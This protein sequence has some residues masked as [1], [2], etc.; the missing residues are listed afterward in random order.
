MRTSRRPI[1]RCCG[2][3]CAKRSASSSSRIRCS[4]SRS[5]SPGFTVGEAEGLR[6]AMSRKRSHAALESYRERFV[7]RRDAQRRR[8]RH[9][10][11]MVYDKLVAFSGLRLPEVALRCVR[12]ARVPVGVAAPSLRRRVPHSAAQRAADGLL[13]AGDARARRRSGTASRRARPTSI[14]AAS[15]ARSRTAPFASGSSTCRAWGRTTRRRSSTTSALAM[16]LRLHPRSRA[17]T[18]LSKRRA[19]RARR[20]RRLRLVRAEAP[21]A[22]VAARPRPARADGAGLGGEEKQLALPLDADRC[23]ARPA[24]AD[25][26]GDECSP[27]T[28]RRASRSAC[29]RS[30]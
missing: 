14:A 26:V 24:R 22:A 11:H 20:V 12:A 5:I 15:T 1:I 21:R 16:D 10:A 19:A 6:R 27:T 3:R 28:A 18:P 9:L 25:G 4:T 29:T 8:R 23:D 17:T 2:S 7:D 30:S 13:S